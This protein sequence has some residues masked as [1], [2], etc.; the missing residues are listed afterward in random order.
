ML[1]I[2]I[3]KIGETMTNLD[4]MLNDALKNDGNDFFADWSYRLSI[5]K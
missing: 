5:Y 1:D 4:K 2:L 3:R